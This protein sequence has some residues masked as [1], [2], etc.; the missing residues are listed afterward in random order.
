M[1]KP[2]FASLGGGV[3]PFAGRRQTPSPIYSAA[4]IVT[5]NLDQERE[6]EK[7]CIEVA[8]ARIRRARCPT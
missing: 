2:P 7:F 5:L 3:A 8:E 4:T 6:Q 1:F